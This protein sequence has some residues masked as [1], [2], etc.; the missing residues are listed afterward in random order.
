[1]EDRLDKHDLGEEAVASNNSNPG[2]ANAGSAP[3]RSG[4]GDGSTGTSTSELETGL[5][6]LPRAAV[7]TKRFSSA[8]PPP[9]LI[10]GGTA[11]S[12]PQCQTIPSGPLAYAFLFP[13]ASCSRVRAEMLRADRDF[14]QEEQSRDLTRE[15]RRAL[16]I[17]W[18]CRIL[19]VFASEACDLA[20]SGAADWSVLMQ[21]S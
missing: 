3:L 13:E 11:W 18:I 21:S 8:P 10:S 7:T 4:G 16:A 9:K 14:E 1:M 15:E 20:H 6:A 17:R 12:P 5:T 2:S 19:G